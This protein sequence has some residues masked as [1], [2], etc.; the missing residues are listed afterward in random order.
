MSFAEATIFPLASQTCCNNP[1]FIGKDI[2]ISSFFFIL[3]RGD[4][5]DGRP[6]G[7]KKILIGSSLEQKVLSSVVV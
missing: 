7:R 6:D 1:P 3:R 2:P 5:G 4:G